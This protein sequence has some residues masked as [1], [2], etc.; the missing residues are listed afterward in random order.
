MTST[1]DFA[2]FYAAPRGS[3]LSAV[4]LSIV[5][6]FLLSQ[7]GGGGGQSRL[8]RTSSTTG[9]RY[10]PTGEE[11][12]EQDSADDDADCG[13]EGAGCDGAFVSER[14]SHGASLALSGRCDLTLT[15]PSARF[16]E[17]PLKPP[18]SHLKLAAR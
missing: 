10:Q 18:L 16:L 1:P 5:Q 11:P 13:D 7:R 12:G 14:G 9:A 3:C 15:S 2:E 4:A 8:V 17:S 6:W